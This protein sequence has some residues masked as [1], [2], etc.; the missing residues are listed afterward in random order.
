MFAKVFDIISVILSA[1]AIIDFGCNYYLESYTATF[2]IIAGVFSLVNSIIQVFGGD[3]KNWGTEILTIIGAILVA[4]IWNFNVF[5]T[6]CFFLCL[7]EIVLL[8]FGWLGAL[9]LYLVTKDFSNK[10][11]YSTNTSR[12]KDNK[13][14]SIF[15]EKHLETILYKKPQ[16]FKLKKQEID[17][18]FS[19]QL[20]LCNLK[21][22][23][24]E[25]KIDHYTE[26]YQND[27]IDTGDYVFLC[28][29]GIDKEDRILKNYDDLKKLESSKFLSNEQKTELKNLINERENILSSHN[30]KKVY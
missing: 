10:K 24:A 14:G 4:V 9:I 25:N 3:Q 18:L 6:I 28:G 12:R 5:R 8:L 26:L 17:K 1:I 21:V 30:S 23:A 20:R 19:N 22:A 7:A 27:E 2:L 13:K 11:N 29:N 15:R 16:I